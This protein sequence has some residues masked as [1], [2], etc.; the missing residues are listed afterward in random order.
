MKILQGQMDYRLSEVG[1]DQARQLSK[2][3]DELSLNAVFAS[4]LSRAYEVRGV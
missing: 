4:D 3:L 2:R 1:V